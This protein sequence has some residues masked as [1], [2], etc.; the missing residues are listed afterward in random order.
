MI[1]FRHDRVKN[2]SDEIEN[3][4]D[5]IKSRRDDMNGYITR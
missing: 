3:H 5:V 4:Y 2:R 1:Q